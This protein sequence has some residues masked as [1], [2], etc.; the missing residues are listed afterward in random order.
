MVDA[1]HVYSLAELI[2]LAQTSNPD[3]RIAWEMA[4]QAALA[5]GMVK[6]LYLSASAIGGYQ[7]SWGSSQVGTTVSEPS[8]IGINLP[9]SGPSN[10]NGTVSGLALQWLL[11]DFGQRD[12][13]KEAAANLSLASNITFNSVHQ[14]IIFDV[15]RSFYD[16]TS[17]RQRV[18]IAEKSREESAR[19]Q[20][21]ASNK[22]KNGIGTTVETAQATQLLA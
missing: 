5:V 15:S 3:T 19:L 11:F 12:A 9:T 10:S 20:E 14:K 22:L 16:Y 18:A 4:R 17:A 21:A 7:R 13:Y 2:D 6:A 1:N 8:Q